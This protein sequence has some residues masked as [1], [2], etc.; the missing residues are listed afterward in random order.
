MSRSRPGKLCPFPH[1]AK[2]EI[3]VKS[4]FLGHAGSMCPR[5]GVPEPQL[6]GDRDGDARA[7]VDVA[8][9]FA[10]RVEGRSELVW[11]GSL[12][13]W[14][15]CST[16]DSGFG[17][18]VFG[19][20]VVPEHKERGEGEVVGSAGEERSGVPATMATGRRRGKDELS[21]TTERQF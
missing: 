4:I 13:G 16:S 12:A 3:L 9:I 7:V 11:P 6:L 18:G 17:L 10:S 21:R 1:D 20:V 14:L 15:S 8:S 5:E 19:F 2:A